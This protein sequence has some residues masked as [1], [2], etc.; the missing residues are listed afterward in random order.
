MPIFEY[1]C[2][3]CDH[4]FELIVRGSA[5]PTTCPSCGATSVEKVISMFAVSSPKTIKRNWD[6]AGAARKKEASAENKERSF[7]EHDDHHH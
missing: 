5:E 4:Q 6:S 2:T 7:Y 1:H 3:S